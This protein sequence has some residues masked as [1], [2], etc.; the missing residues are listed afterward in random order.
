M[1]VDSSSYNLILKNSTRNVLSTIKDIVEISSETRL[2]PNRGLFLRSKVK[3]FSTSLYLL[4]L[5]SLLCR[6]KKLRY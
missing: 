3:D 5:F 4:H 1:S 6:T 2:E